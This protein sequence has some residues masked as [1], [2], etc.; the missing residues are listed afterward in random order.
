MRF[1]LL[2]PV[3]GNR[4]QCGTVTTWPHAAALLVMTRSLLQQRCK[5]VRDE[6]ST[7]RRSVGGGRRARM[8]LQRLRSRTA[9]MTACQ[10]SGAGTVRCFWVGRRCR[11]TESRAPRGAAR[12]RLARRAGSAHS[13]RRSGATRAVHLRSQS[14]GNDVTVIDTPTNTVAHDHPGWRS[15]LWLRPC[16]VIS[17]SSMSRTVATNGFRHQHRDEYGGRHHPRR[18][19]AHTHRSHS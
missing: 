1:I 16:G 6:V 14:S 5:F 4:L 7:E 18:H 10:R 12:V 11:R 8:Y 15:S 19:S 17:H 2:D 9:R 3:A 13:R